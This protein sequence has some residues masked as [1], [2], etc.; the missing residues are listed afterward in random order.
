MFKNENKEMSPINHTGEST[1]VKEI[2]CLSR[3][4]MEAAMAT[5]INR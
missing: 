3:A 4:L 5:R 1:P 2:A